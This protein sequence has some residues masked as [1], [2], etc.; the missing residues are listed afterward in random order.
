MQNTHFSVSAV[1]SFP[2]KGNLLK[3]LHRFHQIPFLKIIFNHCPKVQVTIGLD[4]KIPKILPKNP[5]KNCC[6]GQIKRVV[7]SWTSPIIGNQ[8][9][10]IKLATCAKR[11]GP[12]YLH[13]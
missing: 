9:G 12:K 3:E 4:S 8:W 13:Q 10:D 1:G 6:S 5:F 7:S 11:N 2:G